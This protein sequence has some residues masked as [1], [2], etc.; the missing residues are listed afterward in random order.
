MGTHFLPAVLINSRD[1]ILFPLINTVG[2]YIFKG[3]EKA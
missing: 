2:I 3:M 1:R